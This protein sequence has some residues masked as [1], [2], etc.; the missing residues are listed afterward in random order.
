MSTYTQIIY[1]IVFSTKDR[2]Q[3]LEYDSRNRLFKYMRG[4]INNNKCVLYNINGVEDH[5]H[6]ITH[7]HPTV[8]LASLVKDIKISSSK[9][10]K[11]ERLFSKFRAWQEGYSAFTYAIKDKEKLMKYVDDQIEH[12]K[13]ISFEDELRNLLE[14]HQIQCDEKYFF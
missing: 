2:E 8:A 11:E 6:I 7:I 3:T 10:I 14:E 9:F 12:H 5:L 1:Q 13:V 4:I